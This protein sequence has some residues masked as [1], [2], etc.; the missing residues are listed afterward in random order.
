MCILQTQVYLTF[1]PFFLQ[2]FP[3]PSVQWNVYLAFWKKEQI[4]VFQRKYSTIDEK[5]KPFNRPVNQTLLSFLWV[6]G[7]WF[8]KL[9]TT[10]I[11]KQKINCRVLYPLTFVYILIV[12]IYTLW[13]SSFFTYYF[14]RYFRQTEQKGKT[15]IITRIRSTGLSIRAY[16]HFCEWQGNGL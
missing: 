13:N 8:V 11:T 15:L 14:T 1:L 10:I 4:L 12:Y 6:V 16:C 7:E 2:P 3:W 5:Q 9:A